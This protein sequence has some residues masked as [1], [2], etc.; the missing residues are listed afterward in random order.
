MDYKLFC[1]NYFEATGI[2]I[3]LL[4][5]ALPIY[6]AWGE[7]LGYTPAQAF[8][9]YPQSSNPS[10]E[11]LIPDLEYGLVTIEGT[12][13]QIV[14]GPAFGIPVTDELVRI[15]MR[16]QMLPQE[17]REPLAEILYSTPL[18]SHM[19]LLRHL[20]LIHL[21]LNHKI[22]DNDELH[23]K[24]I[25]SPYVRNSDYTNQ[26]MENLENARLHNTYSFEIGLY[27]C[28][29]EG[30]ENRMIDYIKSYSLPLWEG[31]LAASPLRHAK[32]VFISTV[33]KTALIGAIPGGLE[34]E[35]A[36]Q[37][38]DY[39]IQE[40]ERL[41]DIQA[42]SNLQYAMLLDFCR[43]AGETKI[44]DGISADI[45]LC[46]NYVRT[47]TNEPLTVDDVAAQIGRSSSY[48]MKKFKNELGIHV[49]A[50]ITR[51]K[52]EEAKSMLV[53]TEKSLAEI[54]N[55]LCFS[56][57]SYFQNVFKKQYDITPMQYRKKGRK[58]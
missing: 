25:Q 49:G 29:K 33:Q 37:L 14:L 56:S 30:N 47:H 31:K 18:T 39:Y 16:E 23:G 5:D 58:V 42:I 3:S 10:C 9:I 12:P 43:R 20:S 57:Q 32:N 48:L 1:K 41:Q 35:K 45:F 27:E 53:Y 51:C 21:C 36:Y 46:M 7:M 34:I 13:Y 28:V 11:R 40:C 54:S 44:P 2:P 8:Q 22:M 19:Q 38:M 52:L 55:Y 4:C 15:F 26:R 24:D 17:Y 6:S 50:Y